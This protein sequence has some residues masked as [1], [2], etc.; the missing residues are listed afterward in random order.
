M[1]DFEEYERRRQE[2]IFCYEDDLTD[3]IFV[4]KPTIEDLIDNL[5]WEDNEELASLM[6]WDR[7][8]I[9]KDSICE[10]GQQGSAL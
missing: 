4:I 10:D 3:F 2:L 9:I 1:I 8:E 6:G 7:D 5:D